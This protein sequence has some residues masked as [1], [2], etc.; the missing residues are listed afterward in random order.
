[1][2]MDNSF[3]IK[4]F[5]NSKDVTE[6]YSVIN[7]KIYRACNK[8]D[9]ATISISADIIDNSQFEIPDNKIFNPGTELKFQ[10]GPTDKVNT[11]FEGCVTTHQ[12]KIN[13]EQQTLFILECR[14]FAYP[15]TFGRKNNVYENSKDD[16]V[17]KKILGQYGLSAKVDST[18]IEIP[19]LVQYYCTDWDFVLTR[20]QNNGLV[21]ITDGK[22]VKVCKPN[23][24]ASPVLTITYGD[25]LIAFDG[26]IS[27]SEQYTDTKACA[28][29]VS[30]QQIIKA[31][32]SKPPLNAQGDIAAKDLSGLAN[33]VMLYQTNAPIGDASLHAWA[34]AQA[35]WSGLARFQGSIT[36]YGNASIIP[37]CII[38]LEGLSKHY[39]GNAFVQSVEHTL[40]GGEWKTQ[41]YMG[42]NPVV[43]T[44]EPD[45]VAPAASGFL[46]GIRG[47]QIGIVKKIGDNKDFEN[48]ILVDIPLLQCE[49]TEIWARPVSP[50]ASNGVGMLFLPEVDDEVVLQFINEDPCHPVIVGSLYSRKRKTPVSLDPKNNLKTIVTKNQLK[51][52]LDDDKK[53]I[54]IGTPGENTLIL[55][56]DKKQILLS[57]ANKNKVCMDK[58]GIM[59]ESGKDLIFKARGNVKTEGM[60]IESKS[61]QDSK[62]NGLNIEVSAQMGVKVKGSATAEISA[63]GQTVVKGGVV[64][65]N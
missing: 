26:S 34:D 41:V 58:N 7:A 16:T 20:A 32:A 61:K 50:Y 17:I 24:S 9:K 45:V 47:L 38:K 42:F 28:W 22:Q 2:N 15:A 8:I 53:I 65:I 48:F 25:N 11:L 21:V 62:I 29:D 54:T 57:D 56:D 13:S 19:Q 49:K 3:I 12:L 5:L 60:G 33:E 10:A 14:G 55:D 27:A 36:I 37:G 43:I 1:M 59:V 6:Q 39:S 35:L 52:T 18:G 44:E 23:V 64:M 40:Q 4:L 51:I 63:S 31:T 46:P 30:R